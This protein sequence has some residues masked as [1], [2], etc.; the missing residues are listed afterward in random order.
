M[1]INLINVVARIITDRETGRSRGYGFVTY[2]TPDGASSAIQALD[3]KVI[4]V[5]NLFAFLRMES[6]N[7]SFH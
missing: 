1:L 3:G 7:G 2:A 5:T 4:I 6:A